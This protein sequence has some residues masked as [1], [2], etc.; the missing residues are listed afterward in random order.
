MF[1]LVPAMVRGLTQSLSVLVQVSGFYA[2][3][4]F[5]A[6]GDYFPQS[7][8]SLKGGVGESDSVDKRPHIV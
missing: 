8:P 6:L 3:Y 7:V 1:V 5:Y 2:F 4:A